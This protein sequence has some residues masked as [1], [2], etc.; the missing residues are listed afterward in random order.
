VS[1]AG[2]FSAAFFAVDGQGGPNAGYQSRARRLI[3]M[4][5]HCQKA[6]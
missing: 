3:A 6:Q 5:R 2:V 1:V 4:P